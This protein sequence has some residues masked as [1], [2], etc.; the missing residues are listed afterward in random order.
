MSGHGHS[1][2]DE[3]PGA[4]TPMPPKVELALQYLEKV[5]TK[6]AET[7]HIYNNFLDIMKRFKSQEFVCLKCLFVQSHFISFA[8]F[9]HEFKIYRNTFSDI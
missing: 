1:D 4:D 5:K 2:D 7:P 9:S 6:F 3:T 8:T